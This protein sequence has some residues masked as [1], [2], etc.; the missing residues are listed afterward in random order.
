MNTSSSAEKKLAASALVLVLGLFGWALVPTGGVGG[1][2]VAAGANGGGAGTNLGLSLGGQAG[3]S[4][5]SAGTAQG[6]GTAAG[7]QT[8][9][10]A[11][12]S[13]TGTPGASAVAAGGTQAGTAGSASSPACVKSSETGVSSTQIRVADILLNLA[14]AIGNSAVGQSSPQVQQQMAQAVVDD[15]NAHGGVD[16][17]K[18]VV[19]YYQANPIDPTSTQNIC[20]QI[21]QA[22]VFAVMGGFAYPESANDCL[23]QQRI[24][25][26]ASIAPSPS[27]AKQYYPYMMS[28]SPDPLQDYR[29]S[30][31]GLKARGWFTAAQGFQKLAILEDDC[32][33]EIDNAVYND[34]LGAGVSPSQITK[35]D[36]SCPSGGFASPSDM[37][38]F[39]TQDNLAHVT[40]VVEVTGG[41]SFK[42]YSSAA[43]SQGYKP[44][45][46]VSNYNG[47]MVTATGGTGPDPNNFDGTVATTDTRFG[48]TSSGLTDPATQA[49]IALFARHGLPAD[50]ITGPYLGGVNCNL[51]ELFA[52]AASHDPGLTRAGLAVG[53]G[54][55]GR[56]NMAYSTADSIYTAPGAVT[57]VKVSGGDFWWTIQFSAACTCWKVIDP[58][59]HPTF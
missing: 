6:T 39:A 5:S 44:H 47:F 32:S 11:A 54:Q 50:Y 20:L 28:I 37:S 18:I 38:S 16:C 4:G 42:E 8:S 15:I 45:Y 41:G 55:V 35:N 53:L 46:L 17:R 26:I 19:T 13:A 48:E 12:S 25:L 22:G 30:I 43:Q 24:P 3:S 31:F 21:Q 1:N 56:F 51:F 27:E 57:P 59:W 7:V 49:C 23:A 33:T 34:L 36:F 52:A 9:G 14:G 2:P 58:T 10:G 29:N 40:N